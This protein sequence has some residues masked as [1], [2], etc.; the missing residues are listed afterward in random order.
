[1]LES[2]GL[3]PYV[4]PLTLHNPTPARDRQAFPWQLP[5][6][7][8]FPAL[9][10]PAPFPHFRLP[11]ALSLCFSPSGVTQAGRGCTVSAVYGCLVASMV[12]ATSPGSASVTV[13]GRASSVTKVGK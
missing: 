5:H 12:P 13:A 2:D 9:A 1:M 7:L 4:C 6:I 8:L 10:L 3:I 11:R